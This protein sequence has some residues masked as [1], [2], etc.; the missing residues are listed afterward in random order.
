MKFYNEDIKVN[1]GK[2]PCWEIVEGELRLLDEE[3]SSAFTVSCP[4]WLVSCISLARPQFPV[5][6]SHVVLDV[7]VKAFL[8]SLFWMSFTLKQM[9][10]KWNRS[11]SIMWVGLILSADCLNRKRLTSLKEDEILPQPTFTFNHSIS[12]SLGTQADSPPCRF[13]TYQT[14]QLCDP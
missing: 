14:P 1:R 12:S 5:V 4:W 10:S 11:C 2:V 7:F 3:S 8:L 9:D 13:W 6:W